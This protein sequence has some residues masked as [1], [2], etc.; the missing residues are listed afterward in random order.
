MCCNENGIVFFSCH[1]DHTSLSNQSVSVF[2]LIVKDT[3]NVLHD[4]PNIKELISHFQ[5][6]E[7]CSVQVKALTTS[8]AMK[9]V[10][11]RTNNKKKNH[12][13]FERLLL[14]W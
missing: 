7:L 5:W 3:L 14:S 8:I 4:V 10:C 12:H 6:N 1:F 9:C 2:A 11:A 13:P